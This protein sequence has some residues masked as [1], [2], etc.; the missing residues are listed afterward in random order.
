AA[1]HWAPGLIEMDSEGRSFL[2]RQPRTGDDE[3]ALWRA[4]VACPT[5][6]VGNRERARPPAGVFPYELTPGVFA[7][8]HNAPSSFGGHSYLV[9]RGAGNLMVDS[10]R[11]TRALTQQVDDLGGVAHVLL[12]HRDDIADA[13]RWADR[14]GSRVWIHAADADAAPFATDITTGE[15]TVDDGVVSIPT[16]GHTEGHVVY[17]VDGRW[18]FTGD[19]L[20]WNQRRQELDVTPKQTWF[21]W[22]IL[23][24][25][26]DRIADLAVEWVFAGHG[27]WHHVGAESYVEQMGRLGPEMRAH[28]QAGWAKKP[29]TMFGWY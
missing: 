23:A 29:D 17:L 14:Y 10:P 27:K 3:D 1:R 15:Q 7:L 2:T 28:G 20:F 16:P 13:E 6:S 9:V 22:E 24:D 5:K 21:S 25:S 18:L 8:G 4:S 11:F 26:M 12:S 19:T